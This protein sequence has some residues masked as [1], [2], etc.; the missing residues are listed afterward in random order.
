MIIIFQLKW[1]KEVT[2]LTNL[3]GCGIIGNEQQKKI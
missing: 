2:N 1:L 3:K